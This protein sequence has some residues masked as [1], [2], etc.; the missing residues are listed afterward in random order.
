MH[1]VLQLPMLYSG[2]TLPPAFIVMDNRGRTRERGRER[3]RER[4][5]EMR[6]SRALRSGVRCTPREKSTG[7]ERVAALRKEEKE[8]KEEEEE[9]RGG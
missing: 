3:E 4:E 1:S 2:F 8:E 7:E 5:R 6:F 9:K